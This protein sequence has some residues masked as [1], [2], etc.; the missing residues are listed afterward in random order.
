[1]DAPSELLEGG[2]YWWMLT[3]SHYKLRNLV[4]PDSR[5]RSYFKLLNENTISYK[6]SNSARKICTTHNLDEGGI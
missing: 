3:W 6:K 4:A 1:V 2:R 5:G